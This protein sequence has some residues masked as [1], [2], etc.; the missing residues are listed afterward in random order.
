MGVTMDLNAQRLVVPHHA[1]G[2][3]G[4]MQHNVVAVDESAI[5]YPV[6]R[7][8]VLYNME[9]RSMSFLREGGD[10]KGVHAALVLSPSRKYLAVSERAE[11]AQVSIFHVGSQRRYRVVSC[12]DV[13]SHTFVSAAF[14]ADSKVLAAV[15]GEPDFALVVWLWDKGRVLALQ[16]GAFFSATA[17]TFNPSDSGTIAASGAK[18]FKLWRQ[19]E[20]QLKGSNLG[21]GRAKEHHNYTDHCWLSSDDRIVASTDIG[22]VGLEP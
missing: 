5:V 20:G 17:V 11:H 4:G 6:G 2:L 19:A 13:L 10:F 15:G 22:E 9:T 16:K 8:V 21:T 3:Q 1:F 7:S 18:C 14:S 12:A